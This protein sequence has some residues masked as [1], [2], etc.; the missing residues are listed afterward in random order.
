[1]VAIV[2]G[3]VLASVLGALIFDTSKTDLDVF[4]W[5]SAQVAAHGHPL[6]VYSIRAD[7][8]PDANGPVSLVPLGMV[9]A[10]ADLLGWGSSLEPRDALVLGCFAV[11]SLLL[12][13]EA[14]LAVEAGRGQPTRWMAASLPFLLAPAL[15][16]SLVG[17]GHVEQP[18]E[19]WLVL[20]GV[21]LLRGGGTIRAGICLGLAAATRS[22]AALCLV[23]LLIALLLDRRPRSAARLAATAAL[24]VAAVLAPFV[25]ADR[26]DTVYSLLT[27]RGA[28][29]IVGG[30]LWVAFSGQPWAALVQHWDTVLFA[31]MA[32]LVSLAALARGPRTATSAR[33]L[34]A[35]LAVA[36]AC[37]PMLAKTSWPYYLLDPYVF[38][39]I[40]WLGRPG[41][42]L[43]WQAAPPLLLAAGGVV[44]AAVEPSLPLPGGRGPVTGL[45]ASG[46]MA[47]VVAI[48]V[49]A[50]LGQPLPRGA[51]AASV[52][53]RRC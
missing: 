22:V 42:I 41:G 35:A 32:A 20:L 1:M 30:S 37:V 24:S 39:T 15:W 49:A 7:R 8:Y 5:P 25:L 53:S 27:Y 12:T 26:A 29:P 10:L 6:L 9:A 43:G 21:R 40:W 33:R 48:I 3:F 18:L 45:L 4:F 31:S 34:Y 50:C 46:G 38:A 28:L 2:V 36:T 44:L 14:V 13:R 19:L 16:I 47:L 17:F 23:P 52:Q 11:F 51:P